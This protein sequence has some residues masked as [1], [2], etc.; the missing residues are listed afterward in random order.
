MKFCV[1]SFDMNE[2][3]NLLDSI[4]VDNEIVS[5]T[6]IHGTG[7]LTEFIKTAGVFRKK[8]Y[9]ITFIGTLESETQWKKAIAS[10][11]AAGYKG[12]LINFPTSAEKADKMTEYAKSVGINAES[13]PFGTDVYREVRSVLY[14]RIMEEVGE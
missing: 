7:D 9:D 1:I 11:S 10:L 13:T 3:T 12:L 2:L 14:S 8:D 5:R 4:P 6:Y